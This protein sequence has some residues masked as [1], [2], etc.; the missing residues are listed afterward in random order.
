MKMTHLLLSIIDKI[1]IKLKWTRDLAHQLRVLIA[2]KEDLSSV[3]TIHI[4]KLTTTCVSSSKGS[5]ILF[6]SQWTLGHM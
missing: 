6:C 3:P 4:R 1:K 2:L 5:D